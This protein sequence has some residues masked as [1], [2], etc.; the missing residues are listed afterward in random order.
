[1][2]LNL[3]EVVVRVIYI[4]VVCDLSG[5]VSFVFLIFPLP[6]RYLYHVICGFVSSKLGLVKWPRGS[7]FK[8]SRNRR[9]THQNCLGNF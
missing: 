8:L 2:I 3:G 1:M 4:R 5:F 7:S 6:V 9:K